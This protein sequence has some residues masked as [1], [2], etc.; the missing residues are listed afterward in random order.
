MK[1]AGRK[2]LRVFWPWDSIHWLYL[3]KWL[4]RVIVVCCLLLGYWEELPPKWYFFVFLLLS[5]GFWINSTTQISLIE[6]LACCSLLGKLDFLRKAILVAIWWNE[7]ELSH[8]HTVSLKIVFDTWECS[9]IW[10]CFWILRYWRLPCSALVDP[11][12]TSI[13]GTRRAC[14]C[15]SGLDYFQ[16]RQWSL[17]WNWGLVSPFNPWIS[18]LDWWCEGGRSLWQRQEFLI[19]ASYVQQSLGVPGCLIST[20]PQCLLLHKVEMESVCRRQKA[21]PRHASFA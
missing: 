12:V 4:F 8:V 1:T 13:A 21:F 9:W 2:I 17:V 19:T 6:T 3:F 7:G 18:S 20:S 16:I 10:H 14:N 5:L 11:L 15:H